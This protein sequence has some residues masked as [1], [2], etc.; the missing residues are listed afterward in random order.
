MKLDP[1]QPARQRGSAVIVVIVFLVVVGEIFLANSRSI[2]DLQRNLRRIEQKQI[3]KF[4]VPTTNVVNA[5][6]GTNMSHASNKSYTTNPVTQPP[7]V[8]P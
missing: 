5:P 8:K 4:G 3:K 7:P 6:D 1:K 2:N